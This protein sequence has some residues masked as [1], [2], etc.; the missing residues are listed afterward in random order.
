EVRALAADV[1][2][3]RAVHLVEGECVGAHEP[4]IAFGPPIGDAGPQ[5]WPIPGGGALPVSRAGPCPHERSEWSP[6]RLVARSCF[7][8]AP[9][10][11]STCGAAVAS[12][13]DVRS[14]VTGRTAAP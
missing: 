14:E 4:R 1:G 6:R 12:G 5:R 9:N 13:T 10:T 8:P 7:P 11:S 2:Q 3:A